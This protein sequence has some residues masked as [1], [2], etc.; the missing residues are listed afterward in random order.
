MSV[1]FEKEIVSELKCGTN[2]SYI[3]NNNDNFLT[4]EYKVLQTQ[5]NNGFIKCMKMLFNGKIQLYYF[6]DEE[7]TLLSLLPNVNVENF[8]TIIGNLFYAIIEA[9]GNGFLSCQNIDISFE[10]IFVDSSTYKV[11]LVYLPLKNKI[12][13]DYASFENDLRSSLIKLINNESSLSAAATRQLVTELSDGRL[14]L[15]DIYNRMK[16][17]KPLEG[18]FYSNGSLRVLKL[19]AM[20]APGQ[21]EINITKDEFLIGKNRQLVDA[22]LD[23]NRMISRVHCKIIKKGNSFYL[24]DMQSANGTYINGRRLMG[25]QIYQIKHGDMVRLANSD[26][27][28]IIE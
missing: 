12:Y 11:Q 6:I 10:K 22:V 25:N 17:G 5:G 19:V 7:K 1:L 20:N 13:D 21:I 15:E 28:V 8:L 24:L 4:T 9:K 23:F 27:Q 2:F 18:N 3:L 14:T 16:V 26:F